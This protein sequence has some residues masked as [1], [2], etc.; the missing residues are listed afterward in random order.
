V[1]TVERPRRCAHQ[2]PIWAAWPDRQPADGDPAEGDLPDLP[3][4][5]DLVGYANRMPT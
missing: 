2:V 3:S 4:P 5:P 1:V